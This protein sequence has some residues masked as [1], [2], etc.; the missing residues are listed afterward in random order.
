VPGDTSFRAVEAE[1]PGEGDVE[2]KVPSDSWAMLVRE[3]DG[4]FLE[5]QSPGAD[6][7][8]APAGEFPPGVAD[9]RSALSKG[10][11]DPAR[12][13]TACGCFG[14]RLSF[15][16]REPPPYTVA[17]LVI[18][19][20][21]CGVDRLIRGEGMVP[22]DGEEVPRG[23]FACPGGLRRNSGVRRGVDPVIGS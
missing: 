10:C 3:P 2:S 18:G 23:Q 20:F 19:K 14:D 6:V 7:V 16:Y 22:G 21:D 17:H 9:V 5:E 15:F 12:G 13:F 8:A 11:T 1:Q 4:S